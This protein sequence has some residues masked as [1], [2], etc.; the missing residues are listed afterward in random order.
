MNTCCLLGVSALKKTDEVD[1]SQ[2][3]H[4]R[5]IGFYSFGFKSDSVIPYR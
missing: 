1:M 5:D 2:G 3:S 4:P